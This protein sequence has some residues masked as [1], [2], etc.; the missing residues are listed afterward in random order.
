M[1]AK[2]IAVLV[3]CL[4]LLVI[5]LQNVAPITVHLLFWKVTLSQALLVIAALV[6]GFLAGQLTAGLRRRAGGT[7]RERSPQKEIEP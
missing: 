1:N 4:L 5:V 2:R 7:K 6:L 3:G